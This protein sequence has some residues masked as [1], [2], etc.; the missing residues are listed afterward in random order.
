MVRQY[1]VT[2]YIRP[3]QAR[4]ERTVAVTAGEVHK[5]LGLKNRVPQVCAA[6]RSARF[7]S[8]NHLRLK[9]VS[10]PPSGMSTTVKFTYE[11]ACGSSGSVAT[12]SNPLWRLRGVAKD[13]FK[14]AGEWEDLIKREREEFSD[15]QNKSAR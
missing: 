3:A 15:L 9:D 6:L 14:K 2:Q 8:E 10:G 1:V 4:G 11:I 5:A 13:M 7:L 12:E